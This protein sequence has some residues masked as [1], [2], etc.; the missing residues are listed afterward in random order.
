MADVLCPLLGYLHNL[1]EL[2]LTVDGLRHQQ[3]LTPLPYYLV[4]SGLMMMHL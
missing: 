1:R 2:N 3:R 4:E